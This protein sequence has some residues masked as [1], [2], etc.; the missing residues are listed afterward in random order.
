MTD[1]EKLI[2]DMAMEI[3]R[4]SVGSAAYWT[5]E[6]LQTWCFHDRTGIKSFAGA[7]RQAEAALAVVEM[8]QQKT[9]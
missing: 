4:V 9:F 3:E 8:R 5:E 1:R 6:Q 7:K 2:E